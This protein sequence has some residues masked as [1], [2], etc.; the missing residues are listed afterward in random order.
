MLANLPAELLDAIVAHLP[1]DRDINALARTSRQFHLA[2]NP[3]LYHDKPYALSWASGNGR[4]PTAQLAL[5]GCPNLNLDQTCSSI[6]ESVLSLAA[7]A[8]HEH[9]VEW[10]LHK[11]LIDVNSRDEVTGRTALLHAIGAGHSGVIASLLARPGID[12]NLQGTGCLYSPLTLAV[13]MGNEQVVRQLLQAPLIDV[14]ARDGSGKTPLMC[15]AE[16]G[17]V[18]IVKLL[19]DTGNVK[20]GS[21]QTSFVV[22]ALWLA[23]E[24]VVDYGKR[25]QLEIVRLLLD[26]PGLNAEYR[27]ENGDTFLIWA[28]RHGQLDI[29]KLVLECGRFDVAAVNNAGKSAFSNAAGVSLQVMQCLYQTGLIDVNKPDAVPGGS[30]MWVA[31]RANYRW[32]LE[33][34]LSR[35]GVDVGT[36][37]GSG[38]TLL[39]YAVSNDLPDMVD[40]L[41]ASPKVDPNTKN[42]H[43][44]TPLHRA[45][46]Q[47]N[48]KLV[49]TL[50]DSDKVDVNAGDKRDRTAMSWAVEMGFNAVAKALLTSGRADVLKADVNGVTPLAL[51]KR[52]RSAVCI[53]LMWNSGQLDYKLERDG[54]SDSP[55]PLDHQAQEYIDTY[56]TDARLRWPSQVGG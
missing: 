4:I 9:M 31:V 15:A 40:A 13:E 35:D 22:P 43:G 21:D 19:L 52:N 1:A 51:A 25:E 55:R 7:K 30:P 29:V 14:D 33:W 20:D 49:K 50:V 53:Q 41:L 46:I 54:L 32:S 6:G 24:A 56:L 18:S 16:Y 37:D 17:P 28:A 36:R 2:I 45:T 42:K 39:E 3:I 26:Q 10:L 44:E 8:G 48:D 47:G 34:L 12:V 11:K 27:G 5:D 23:A 38:Y